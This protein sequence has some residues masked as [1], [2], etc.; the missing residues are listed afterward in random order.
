MEV[1]RTAESD[2]KWTPFYRSCHSRSSLL[3]LTKKV[4]LVGRFC[5]REHFR[6]SCSQ[7]LDRFQ[8]RLNHSYLVMCNCLHNLVQAVES[9]RV[10]RFVT[11]RFYFSCQYTIILRD[12]FTDQLFPL[13]RHIVLLV[14]TSKY[15]LVHFWTLS[16]YVQEFNHMLVPEMLRHSMEQ[17]L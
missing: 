2:L 12:I 4:A 15:I 16:E 7:S 14:V 6:V 3:S 11:H 17:I 9:G 5:R 1:E 8:G 10:E 13:L